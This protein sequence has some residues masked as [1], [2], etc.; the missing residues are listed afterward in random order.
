M[1]TLRPL[2]RRVHRWIG[3][4]IALPVAMQGLTGAILALEP[5]VP[6][7]SEVHVSRTDPP[8]VGAIIDAARVVVGAG[9]H[10][11]RYTPAAAGFPAR[12]QISASGGQPRVL[13]VDPVDLR[14]VGDEA[15]SAGVLRLLRS[16]HVQFAAPDYGGRGIGGWS[17]I[18]LLLLLVTGI[19]VWWPRANGWK[20]SLTIAPRTR[21]RRFYRR[22]HG[23]VGAWSVL[24]LL[25]LAGTGVVLAFPRT[26]RGLLGLEAG[27]PLRAMQAAR[28][29]AGGAAD[30]DRAIAQARAAVPGTI[31]RS[32][33]L[34]G[35]PS[36]AVRVMLQHPDGEGAA[37]SAL[38][39]VDS[40]SGRVLAIDDAR[41]GPAAGL[42]YR[43]M[44]DLHEG[45][46]LGSIW[47]IL[48]ALGGFCLP[49][50]ALTGPMMWL[51]RRRRRLVAAQATDWD[52][53]GQKPSS[54]D[55]ALP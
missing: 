18:G 41:S 30:L 15:A 4:A 31:L 47:R 11:V 34:P 39:Q 5:L 29:G 19:P 17:G 54:S 35:N 55:A 24:V 28:D 33:L 45:M 6:V 25:V 26:A 8:S 37:A 1:I 20:A 14:V 40:V 48:A 10:T 13:S 36:E 42:A 44:H 12:V 46:G 38:V 52:L 3:L 23:A 9:A 50:F 32:V 53:A 21:G 51:L 27:G 43:W 22:L 7:A 2:L 16:L 49:V